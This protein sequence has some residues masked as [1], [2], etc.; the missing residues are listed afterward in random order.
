MIALR[1]QLRRV[2][3]DS[4]VDEVAVAVVGDD[5]VCGTGGL[6]NGLLILKKLIVNFS[7]LFCPLFL[8]F[9]LN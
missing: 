6:V 4:V 1:S 2:V 5:V 7:S 3:A 8:F 9:S